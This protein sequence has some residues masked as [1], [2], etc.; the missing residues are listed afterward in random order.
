MVRSWL[1]KCELLRPKTLLTVSPH[2]LGQEMKSSPFFGP[3][4]EAGRNRPS[5]KYHEVCKLKSTQYEGW[6]APVAILDQ[7]RYQ[8]Q[9]W[10]SFDDKASLKK[11]IAYA[12]GQRLAGISF[13][14]I[15]D[16]DIDGKCDDGSLPL[17]R[18]VAEETNA[19]PKAS[20]AKS[21]T[22]DTSSA[23]DKL[24][25]FCQVAAKVCSF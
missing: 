11:K 17:F 15:S 7:P 24:N 23:S 10:V 18:S 19:S 9:Y 13:N 25:A 22:V 3:L 12:R 5:Y 4:L 8:S 21:L 14:S 6:E 1:G 16:D 20:I 2:G